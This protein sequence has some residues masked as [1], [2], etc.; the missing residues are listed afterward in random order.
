MNELGHNFTMSSPRKKFSKKGE[1][2]AEIDLFLENGDEVMAVEAKARFKLGEMN[3]FLRHVQLLRKNEKITGV[4]GKTIYVAVAA[5]GFD[6][7]ARKLAI[8]KGMYIIDI[9]QDNENIILTPP[10]KGKI[11]KW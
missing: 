6:K 11:G 1:L 8:E 4:A 7:P 2:L 10:P 5:I 3:E 9:D